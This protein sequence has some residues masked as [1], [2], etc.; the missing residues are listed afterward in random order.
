MRHI[1]V[2]ALLVLALS[3]GLTACQKSSPG[4]EKDL[5][6]TVWDAAGHF[7][8]GAGSETT[9][10]N[11]SFFEGNKCTMEY[12]WELRTKMSDPDEESSCILTGTFS[13]KGNRLTVNLKKVEDG[14]FSGKI[15][16]TC[17]GNWS[18]ADII[19]LDIDGINY[20]F[21]RVPITFPV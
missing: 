3:V 21:H 1:K 4:T 19:Y 18:D 14:F 17:K 8:S 6:N 15:P 16:M 10:Y 20:E 12:T 7:V 11:L 2:F 13:L 5:Y 9:R